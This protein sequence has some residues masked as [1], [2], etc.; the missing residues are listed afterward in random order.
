VVVAAIA[1]AVGIVSWSQ[2]GIWCRP[3]PNLPLIVLAH[4]NAGAFRTTVRKELAVRIQSGSI[5]GF[6]AH[7]MANILVVELRHD[8]IHWNANEARD[9]LKRMWPDSAAALERELKEGDG[10]S[11]PVAAAVLRSSSPIPSTALLEACVKDLAD[12]SHEPGNYIRGS[13]AFAAANYL[14]LWQSEARQMLHEAMKSDDTHQRLLAAALC[15]F[16]GDTT[17]IDRAVPI[18]AE[19]LKDNRMSGDGM[20]AAPALF[21]FGPQ[22]IPAIRPYQ[23][24]AD[25]QLRKSVLHIIERLEHPK[26]GIYE[27]EHLMPRVTNR[28]HDPLFLPFS[29]AVANIR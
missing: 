20:L 26:R 2:S 27:C 21:R 18:L 6:Q 12:D 29:Q 4:T 16:A 3:L 9:L 24:A 14:I 8:T 22:V 23:T 19:H 11:R 13:N 15:G 25:T 28:F 10:Q 1:L 17:A 7:V 5:T